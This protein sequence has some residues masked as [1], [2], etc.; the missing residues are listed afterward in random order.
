[1]PFRGDLDAEEMGGIVTWTP[2][3]DASLVLVY[4]SL[5][6]NNSEADDL[7]PLSTL[8]RISTS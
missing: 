5:V 6:S 3:E 7:T 4:R 2:P 8:W 1:M